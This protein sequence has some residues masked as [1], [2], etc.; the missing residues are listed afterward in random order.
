MC[1]KTVKLNFLPD[2]NK[3]FLR[4]V[5]YQIDNSS[6]CTF[7]FL[8]QENIQEYVQI[9]YYSNEK[10]I[11]TITKISTTLLTI[12]MINHNFPYKSKL[13][14]YVKGTLITFWK[15]NTSFS[16]KTVLAGKPKPV[17]L[18]ISFPAARILI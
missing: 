13:Y 14:F 5:F 1:T 9:I 16:H 18:H 10:C 8:K 2:L 15:F 17:K 6:I 7:L 4:R 11:K 3:Y 12:N